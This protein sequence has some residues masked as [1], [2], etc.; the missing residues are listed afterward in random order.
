MKWLMRSTILAAVLLLGVAG[1]LALASSSKRT[2]ELSTSE[3]DV[4]V[5]TIQT[6]P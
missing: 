2:L 1:W 5:I 3:I 4:G 6:P